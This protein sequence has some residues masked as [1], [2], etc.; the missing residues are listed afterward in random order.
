MMQTQIINKCVRIVL[1]ARHSQ[2]HLER[3]GVDNHRI[4]I[5]QLQNIIYIVEV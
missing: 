4:E 5:V 2:A 1:A 3:C